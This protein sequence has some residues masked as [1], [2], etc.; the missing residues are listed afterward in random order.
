VTVK[1]AGRTVVNEQKS[2]TK[3]CSFTVSALTQRSSGKRSFTVTARFAGN[4]VLAP[5]TASRRFS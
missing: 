5:V 3:S 2:I 1:R 4:A